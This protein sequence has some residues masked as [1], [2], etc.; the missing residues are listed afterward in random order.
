MGAFQSRLC[1]YHGFV[2][3]VSK[4]IFL[5]MANESRHG[6]RHEIPIDAKPALRLKNAEME[7]DVR[8]TVAG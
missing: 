6:R 2:F 4:L 7:N 1:Q 3:G 8:A 5:V